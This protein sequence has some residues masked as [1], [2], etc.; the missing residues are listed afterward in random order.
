MPTLPVGITAE[1]LLSSL[2]CSS[3]MGFGSAGSMTPDMYM[4]DSSSTAS[5]R[6]SEAGGPLKAAAPPARAPEPH[7]KAEEPAPPPT[8]EMLTPADLQRKVTLRLEETETVW[9][10]QLAGG[11][12]NQ[13]TPEGKVVSAANTRYQEMVQQKESS[14]RYLDNEAQTLPGLS[15]TKETQSNT[16]STVST[17]VQASLWDIHDALVGDRE[18]EDAAEA[19]DAVIAAR[20][21]SSSG[22]LDQGQQRAQSLD[23]RGSSAGA[24]DASDMGRQSGSM[25][26]SLMAF[27]QGRLSVI[28]EGSSTRASSAGSGPGHGSASGLGGSAMG[29]DFQG[30]QASLSSQAPS[31]MG[32]LPSVL[33]GQQGMYSGGFRTS[34]DAVQARGNAFMGASPLQLMDAAVQ[35]NVYHEKLLLYR[36]VLVRPKATTDRPAVEASLGSPQA[37]AR[38]QLLWVRKDV[39]AVGYGHFNFGPQQPGLVAFWSLKNPGH[40]LWTFPTSSGVTAVDFATQS[41]NM[42]A[43][44]LYDGTLAVHDV[45]TRQV[46]ALNT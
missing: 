45:S 37:G 9:L 17:A 25:R 39:L 42:L 11:C 1:L 10:L 6:T 22:G 34:E 18:V 36:D 44:G 38:L 19:P 21:A 15:K 26:G 4:D 24:A 31:M 43:V 33:Q 16:L 13:E 27:D 35:Q 5:P 40:P 28:E 29:S 30:S 46:G 8:P 3:R 32:N 23:R 12:V 2:T 14:D 7:A 20:R 41:P